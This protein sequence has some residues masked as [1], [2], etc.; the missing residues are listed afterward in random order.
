MAY[1]YILKSEKNSKYYIGSTNNY[2]KRIQQHNSGNVRFTKSIRPLKL[3]LVQEY[4]NISIA[5]KIENKLKKLKRKDYIDKIVK[6][7]FIKL[8]L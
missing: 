6:E 4:K 1:V 3:V 2:K 5:R 8:G 7:G